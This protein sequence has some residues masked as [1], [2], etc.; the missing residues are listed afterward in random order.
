[1]ISSTEVIPA[2]LVFEEMDGK[3]LYYKG[4]RQ[5]LDNKKSLED[6]LGSSF[7]QA[8]IVSIVG[9]YIKGLLK[10]KDYWV[11]SNEAGLH[12][13]PGNNLA[14]DIAVFDKALIKDV[15]SESYANVP[16]K[17]AVEVDSKIEAEHI[18]NPTDYVFLKSDKLIEFGT[19]RVIWILTGSRKILVTDQSRKWTIHEWH[20]FIPLFDGL[21]ICLN[22]L[23]KEEGV[24]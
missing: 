5:V 6:I 17:I 4:Y 18:A 8:L 20:E 11:I 23:L 21:E 9:S 10:G 1:M 16:P 15:F 12:L 14:N 3:P 2:M 24:I 22:D 19:E 7:I 13:S